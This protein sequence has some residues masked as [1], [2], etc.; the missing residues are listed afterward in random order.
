MPDVQN[1][2]YIALAVVF[3]K[4]QY[5][6]FRRRLPVSS[7][8]WYHFPVAHSMYAE[9]MLI[10]QFFPKQTSIE[11]K[12]KVLACTALIHKIQILPEDHS[13]GQTEI[14]IFRESMRSSRRRRPSWCPLPFPVFVGRYVCG[15]RKYCT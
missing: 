6:Y 10:L 5:L 3:A 1:V 11:Q 4:V 7:V 9:G 12:S 13:I 14:A 15:K 2:F 8:K